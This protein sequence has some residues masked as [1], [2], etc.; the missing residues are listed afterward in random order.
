MTLDIAIHRNIL[1]HILKDIFTDEDLGVSLGFKGGTAAYLFYGLSRFSVDLDFD[2][3]DFAQEDLVFE[4]LRTILKEYGSLLDARKKRFSFFYLLSYDNKIQ[5]AYNIKIEINRRNFGS[6]YELKSYLSIPMK[7][8][9]QEDMFANKLVA[10]FERMGKTNRD[11]FD[12]WFFLKNNWPIN[13]KIIEKRTEMSIQQFLQKCID[14]LENM[15]NRGILSGIGELLD[16]KQKLWA[17]E[18]LKSETIFLLKLK[19]DSLKN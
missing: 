2:L 8:M 10:M 3:L 15:S 17:K 1:I 19:L 14:L 13:E 11:I 7:V 6:R 16:S 4:K 9:I 12:V 5:N 18:K